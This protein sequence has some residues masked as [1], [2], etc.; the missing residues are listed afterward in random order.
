MLLREFG[1]ERMRARTRD[2]FL[3]QYGERMAFVG[4]FEAGSCSV[5]KTVTSEGS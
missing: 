2:F 5:L 3:S 4:P 1:R